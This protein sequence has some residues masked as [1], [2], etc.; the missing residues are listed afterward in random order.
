MVGRAY[1]G[2]VCNFFRGFAARGRHCALFALIDRQRY[3][4]RA[5]CGRTRRRKKGARGTHD[6]T[7]RR[8]EVHALRGAPRRGGNAYNARGVAVAVG[9]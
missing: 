8:D 6:G 7:E 9:R 1:A 4:I 2:R 3:G 5:A